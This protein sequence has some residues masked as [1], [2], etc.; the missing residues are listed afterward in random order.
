MITPP[1]RGWLADEIQAPDLVALN[2]WYESLPADKGLPD[3]PGAASLEG[4]PGAD[5]LA[6]LRIEADG[7]MVYESQG[8]GYRQ[9]AGLLPDADGLIRET[10]AV[11]RQHVGIVLDQARPF[12]ISITRWDGPRILQ[13]DR[14]LLP[15][16]LASAR[17]THVL[18]GETFLRLARG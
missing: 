1:P 14:L 17:I 18:V 9:L 16:G 5:D 2:A 7:A 11:M 13:Y 6:L 10:R 3:A 12:H 8:Q 15:F 4:L